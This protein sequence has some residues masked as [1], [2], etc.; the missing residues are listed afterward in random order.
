LYEPEV[1]KNTH[2]NIYPAYARLIHL[3]MAVFGIA[4][5]LTGELAEDHGAST[6]YL[7]HAYLGLSLAAFILIRVCMGF[8][9]STALSF[10]GSSPFSRVQWQYALE[11]FRAL[12]KLQV[13]ERDRHQGLA[14][15]V[16]AFGLIVFA[17][18]AL[19]GAGLYILGNGAESE[20][21]EALE[22]VHEVG[23]SLIP[24]YLVAHVGAVLLH[25][26]GGHPVWK[27][28]FTHG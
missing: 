13:P 26:L 11:D 1:I 3:G 18:M 15:L 12:L 21:F 20:L 4:A 28:M 8:T 22:E 24:L 23:E 10:K 17:W 27:K 9:R 25:S 19:T 7:L 5:F 6:G 2:D 14:G 16:Q